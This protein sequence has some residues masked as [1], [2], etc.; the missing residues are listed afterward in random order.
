MSKTVFK[1]T[2]HHR[3]L[4]LLSCGIPLVIGITTLALLLLDIQDHGVTDVQLIR[5]LDEFLLMV[6]IVIFCE[7]I[8]KKEGI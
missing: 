8:W 5:K 7:K 1:N 3:A 4:Q 6:G 2:F